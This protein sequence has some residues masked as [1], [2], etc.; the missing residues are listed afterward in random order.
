MTTAPTT[1]QQR[2]A[3]WHARG[4]ANHT[5]L[6]KACEHYLHRRDA[7]TLRLRGG[8]G[9]RAGAPDLVAVLPTATGPLFAGIECKTGSGRLSPAQVRE[10]AALEAV[11]A[12][13]VVVRQVEDLDAALV[14][15]GLPTLLLQPATAYPERKEANAYKRSCEEGR[16]P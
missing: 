14:A 5:A 3:A 16:A 6:L 9:M 1:A 12:L 15:V 13:H 11:G 4:T 7:W 10:R 8:L 2:A